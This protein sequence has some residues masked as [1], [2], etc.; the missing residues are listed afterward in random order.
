MAENLT[1]T[2][3]SKYTREVKKALEKDVRPM[4][5]I[6]KLQPKEHSGIAGSLKLD[7]SPELLVSF[8]TGLASGVALETLKSIWKKFFEVIKDSPPQEKQIIIINTKRYEFKTCECCELLPKS[9]E[10]DHE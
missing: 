4:G 3:Q 6:M 9:M 1:I 8:S 7:I 10:K 5:F 2:I